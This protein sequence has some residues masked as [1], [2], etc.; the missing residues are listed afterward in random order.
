[1]EEKY[2]EGGGGVDVRQ[3][4]VDFSAG[5]DQYSCNQVLQKPEE[6]ATTQRE[7]SR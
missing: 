5:P 2:L 6:Y 1:M 7:L 3:V 4:Q